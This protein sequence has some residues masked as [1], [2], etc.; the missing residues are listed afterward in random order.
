MN[1]WAFEPNGQTIEHV[2][3]NKKFVISSFFW[4]LIFVLVFTVPLVQGAICNSSG[5]ENPIGSAI[6]L[7][8]TSEFYGLI[9]ELIVTSDFIYVSTVRG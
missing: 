5:I 9:E 7:S 6:S 4:T 2:S 8:H 1:E 3:K